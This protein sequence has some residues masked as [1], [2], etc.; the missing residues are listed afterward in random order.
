MTAFTSSFESTDGVIKAKEHHD[1]QLERVRDQKAQELYEE[2]TADSEFL[3]SKGIVVTYAAG[4][5]L[6]EVRGLN[7]TCLYDGDDQAFY[8]VFEKNIHRVGRSSQEC[9]RK[10]G[11]FAAKLIRGEPVDGY[12][13]WK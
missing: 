3:N 13:G 8:I 9:A 7:F 10:L 5:V 12:R 11:E 1:K 4:G 6:F 2:L